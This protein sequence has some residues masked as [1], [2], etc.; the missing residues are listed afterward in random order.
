MRCQEL[1]V[2][3]T[4]LMGIAEVCMLL[5]PKFY[6]HTE[7]FKSGDFKETSADSVGLVTL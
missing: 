7:T 1:E 3:D 5:C 4:N 6:V 2:L